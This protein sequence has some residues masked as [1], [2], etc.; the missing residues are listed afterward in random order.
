MAEPITGYCTGG[1]LDEQQVSVR[2]ATFLAVDRAAGMSWVYQQTG[3]GFTVCTDHDDS[4][5]YPQGAQ[6]G[7]RRFDEGRA[8]AAGEASSLDIIAVGD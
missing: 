6:T 4:L 7:E 2:T 3:D 5:I 1:P 8:T